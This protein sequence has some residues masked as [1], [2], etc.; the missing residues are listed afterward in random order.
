MARR[1]RMLGLVVGMAVLAGSFRATQ[2]SERDAKVSGFKLIRTLKGQASSCPSFSPDGKLLAS[3]SSGGLDKDMLRLFDVATGKLIR[4]TDLGGETLLAPVFVN[5]G[6]TLAIRGEKDPKY[7]EGIQYLRYRPCIHLLEVPS[8]AEKTKL[9]PSGEDYVLLV[10]SLDGKRLAIGTEKSAI[11]WDLSTGKRQWRIRFPQITLQD[12]KNNRP[13]EY[14]CPQDMAFAPDGRA[15]AMSFRDGATRLFNASNGRELYRLFDPEAQGAHIDRLAFSPDGK[16]LAVGLIRE[17]MLRLWDMATG[18]AEPRVAIRW[19]LPRGKGSLPVGIHSLVFSPDSK[20]VAAACTDF[21]IRLWEVATGKLR[22]EAEG[23]AFLFVTFS[24]D[25][26]LL[27]SSC[28]HDDNIFLWD[29]RIPGR[30]TSQA[31]T[32]AEAERFWTDLSSPDGVIAYRAMAALASTPRKSIKLLERVGPADSITP[33]DIDRLIKELNDDRFAVRNRAAR[34]LFDLGAMVEAR[35]RKE[36]SQNKTL[37][38]RKRIEDV[39][40]RLK[41]G[42]PPEQLRTLRA[43]ELLEYLGTPDAREILQKLSKG[44]AERTETEDAK[45]ALKRLARRGLK[46]P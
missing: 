13:P 8:L 38:A 23:R 16:L 34:Q 26:R 24:P 14:L 33:T 22:H 10:P 40:H 41:L 12:I 1:W 29:W 7:R 30:P 28:G 39:L 11:L 17:N 32:A 9:D 37:E 4:Q 3:V 46:Q 44:R 36:L 19:G 6:R 25:G 35:L 27:A 42:P 2:A 31:M 20:T 21:K 43:I 5:G 18:E 15:V 45:A